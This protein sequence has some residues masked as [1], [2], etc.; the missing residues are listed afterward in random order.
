[1]VLGSVMV[2]SDTGEV[3]FHHKEKLVGDHPDD[4]KLRAAVA[5]LGK[6]GVVACECEWE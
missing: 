3:L 1:M 2:V 4:K 6:T 5:Q